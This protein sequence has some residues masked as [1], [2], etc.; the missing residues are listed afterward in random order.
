MRANI[1]DQ[2]QYSA[3]IMKCEKRK[4]HQLLCNWI[5][6]SIVCG[7]EFGLETIIL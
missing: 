3:V 7:T 5:N 6:I 2:N 1:H 4:K